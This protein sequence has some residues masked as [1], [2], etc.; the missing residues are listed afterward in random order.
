MRRPFHAEPDARPPSGSAMMWSITPKLAGDR[1]AREA[2]RTG[3]KRFGFIRRHSPENARA[4]LG[5]DHRIVGV[6]QHADAVAD[7]DAQCPAGPAFAD[8]DTDNRRAESG[9]LQNARRDQ[10]GLA[11]LLGSDSRKGTR[12][13]DQ[14]DHREPVL[15]GQSHLGERLAVPFGVSTAVEALQA[16]RPS[17]APFGARSASPSGHRFG[18]SL[19]GAPGRPRTPDR[20]ATRRIRRRP[21]R[22]NRASA[23]GPCGVR[24]A[25]SPT[26]S[27]WRSVRA[28]GARAPRRIRRMASAAPG[29]SGAA[30]SRASSTSSSWMSCSNGSGAG[31]DIGIPF[32][33]I[34]ATFRCHIS[35]SRLLD[36][37]LE[38]SASLKTL[39]L[40]AI[41]TSWKFCGPVRAFS[42]PG[43]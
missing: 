13:V 10:L 20:R 23:A 1:L 24:P 11:A 31:T 14:A 12:R 28:S 36:H 17:S 27:G 37:R 21:C 40:S 8:H 18:R 25:P 43:A 42:S 22:C 39:T 4:A 35:S 30:S 7:A 34:A 29:A 32:S 5:A 26:A 19:S 6:L 16:A 2:Q 33:S 9:H 38:E 15:R 41:S 3:R